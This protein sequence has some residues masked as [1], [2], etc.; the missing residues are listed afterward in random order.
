MQQ[1]DRRRTVVV[2]RLLELTIILIEMW[3][4]DWSFRLI[5]AV[6]VDPVDLVLLE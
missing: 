4:S 2:L 6:F 1:G 3:W 5:A